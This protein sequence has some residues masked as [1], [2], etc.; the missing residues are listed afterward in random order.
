MKNLLAH[1]WSVCFRTEECLLMAHG[2]QKKTK[3]KHI[4]LN[5]S[6]AFQLAAS[7]RDSRCF[8]W[9]TNVWRCWAGRRKSNGRRWERSVIIYAEWLFTQATGKL[10]Y[11]TVLLH[12]SVKAPVCHTSRHSGC[13]RPWQL[14]LSCG[15]N[16]PVP[17]LSSA[18]NLWMETPSGPRG[19]Y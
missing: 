11:S 13:L 19:G 1:R 3:I 5:L 4:N 7:R 2:S 10:H 9:A 16:S 18:R 14:D 15:S 6:A 17:R 8:V 12:L